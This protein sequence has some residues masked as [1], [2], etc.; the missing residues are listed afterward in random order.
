MC[1]PAAGPPPPSVIALFTI[2]SSIAEAYSPI[3]FLNC[4]TMN[5]SF[6]GALESIRKLSAAQ[7]AIEPN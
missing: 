5:R 2:G 3:K 7:N 1:N 6:L 4:V